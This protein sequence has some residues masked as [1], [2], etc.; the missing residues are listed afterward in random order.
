MDI[1]SIFTTL[2]SHG[3]KYVLVGALGAVAHGARME[4]ADVDVCIA[5][6]EANLRRA[7][8]ALQEMPARL[9]REPA[10]RPSSSVDLSD[11]R[12]LRLGDPS[13]HHLFAT[14][15]GDIDVLPEPFGPGGWGSTTN[16]ALLAPHAIE[17]QA[18]DLAIPVAAFEDIR[19][20][21]LALGR[22]QDLVAEAELG[23]VNRL[24]AQGERPDF[25]LEHFAAQSVQRMKG[26]LPGS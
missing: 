7:A 8:A 18:F 19:A 16:Y 24:L 20:S 17:V 26:Q 5:T 4:T 21:K 22:E 10:T 13:E 15:F 3:V 11:W 2:N 14:P 9:I 23:H 1:K 12:S 6:D 25:R